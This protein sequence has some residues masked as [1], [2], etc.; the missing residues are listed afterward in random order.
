MPEP[1]TL[2]RASDGSLFETAS[3]AANH[4]M[5]KALVRQAR[6]YMQRYASNQSRISRAKATE[7]MVAFALAMLNEDYSEENPEEPPEKAPDS[8]DQPSA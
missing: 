8:G 4:D 3:E 7:L 6:A 2:Y 5:H 1:V